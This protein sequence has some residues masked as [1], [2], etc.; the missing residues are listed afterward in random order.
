M[1]TCLKRRLT[2]LGL[3][4]HRSVLNPFQSNRSVT[5]LFLV[6]F[7]RDG[8]LQSPTMLPSLWSQQE[9]GVAARR[10][11]FFSSTISTVVAVANSHGIPA[12]GVTATIV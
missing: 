3:L 6:E 4:V 8:L 2:T 11:I 7:F 10:A 1:R 9:D 12:V 5:T